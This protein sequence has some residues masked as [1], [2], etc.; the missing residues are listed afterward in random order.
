[1]GKDRSNQ[2]NP[3]V[4]EPAVTVQ[5]LSTNLIKQ[6]LDI[7]V[8]IKKTKQINIEQPKVIQQLKTKLLHEDFSEIVLHQDARYRHYANNL[9]Q[10]VV[11]E[12]NPDQAILRRN[13]EYKK[14]S[15]STSAALASRTASVPSRNGSQAPWHLQIVAGD[16]TKVLSP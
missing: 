11:K 12:K 16:Q 1:M 5:T 15:K 6:Q 13:R 14:P 7:Q 4:E 10:I 9:E 2:K 8:Q 3:A